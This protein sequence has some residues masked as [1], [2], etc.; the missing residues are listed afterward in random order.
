EGEFEEVQE[1]GQQEGEDADDNK[2]TPLPTRDANEQ[3][4]DPEITVDA[5]K[6]Q[7]ENGGAHE[8]EHHKT[9]Q[10]GGGVH[11]LTQQCQ[12]E[13]ATGDGHDKGPDGPHGATF[14]GRGQA[15]EDGPQH[16]KD[17]KQ[18]RNHDKGDAFGNGRQQPQAGIAVDKRHD[19]R[20]HAPYEQRDHNPFVNRHLGVR[21]EIM[22]GA[23]PG[24]GRRYQREYSQRLE[25]AR[26]VGLFVDTGFGG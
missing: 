12:A 2:K 3:V 18:G 25:P 10:L 11:G 19:P 7:A 13:T 26:A 21:T 17:Q 5:A 1:K 23:E 9:R 6:A 16:Q 22:L 14:G 24:N 15:D 20:R 4:L 8:N